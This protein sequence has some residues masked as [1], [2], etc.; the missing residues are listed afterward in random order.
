MPAL[1]GAAAHVSSQLGPTR[2]TRPHSAPFGPPARIRSRG[3]EVP[4]II[5][6]DIAMGARRDRSKMA[7]AGRLAPQHALCSPVH[8]PERPPI[9]SGLHGFVTP[10]CRNACQ[11]GK[12]SPLVSRRARLAGLPTR[13]ARRTVLSYNTVGRSVLNFGV[14]GRDYFPFSSARWHSSLW[15]KLHSTS[16]PLAYLTAAAPWAALAG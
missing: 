9:R 15:C 7:A 4:V 14:F 16:R 3:G 6:C 1:S 13:T 10:R 5:G 12:C 8:T 11:T 2:C